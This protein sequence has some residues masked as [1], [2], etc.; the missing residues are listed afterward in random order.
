MAARMP[1]RPSTVRDAR[2]QLLSQSILDLG[3]LRLDLERDL[4]TGIPEV[5]IAEGKSAAAIRAAVAGFVAERGRAIV[6]RAPPR[7][8]LGGLGG[9]VERHPSCGVIVV[10]RGRRTPATGGRIAILTGG[11][12]DARVADEA[13]VVASELG[14]EVRLEPDVGV[15]SL[16]RVVSAVGRLLPW[17]PHVVI[18]CAGR[19]GALA[20]V[21]AGLVRGP[22]IGVP[23]STGYGHHGRGEAALATMLQSCSPL[24]T[25]NID[26]GFVAGAVAA[27]IANRMAR[28]EK[29]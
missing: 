16:S 23:V 17:D 7:L 20:P 25:V 26:A 11:A 13:R 22:I 12:S 27:Q 15:A 2:R 18:V 4:R 29:P 3:D 14:C 5:V 24:V 21:V 10:R 8:N 28:T 6:T 9:R 19:E 1:R